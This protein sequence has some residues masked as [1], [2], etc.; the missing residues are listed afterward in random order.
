MNDKERIHEL[1]K[2]LQH[3]TILLHLTVERLL[4]EEHKTDV[5]VQ[6]K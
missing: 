5:D 2:Q 4:E 1:E 3:A 6:K